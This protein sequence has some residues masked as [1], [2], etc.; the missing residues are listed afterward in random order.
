M[1][2]DNSLYAIMFDEMTKEPFFSFVMPAYK[3]SFLK[4]SI[5]SILA[6]TYDNF[7]LIIVDDAS[8]YNLN[9]IVNLYDDKRIK[10]YINDKNIG[11]HN[12]VEQWNRSLSYATG[13]YI[14]L[15][16]DDDV[17]MPLYL[18]EIVK[19]IKKYPDACIF[20]PRIQHIDSNG[21]I[22]GVESVMKEFTPSVEFLYNWI[23]NTIF[24][25]I[26]FYVFKRYKLNEIGNFMNY[27]LAWY[28][29]DH[30]V[31]EMSKKGIICSSEVLFSFRISGENIS[32]RKN[33]FKDVIQKLSA[34]LK[35]RDFLGEYVANLVPQ[36]DY[37]ICMA[38]SIVSK[39][40]RLW[41]YGEIYD[42]ISSTSYANLIRLTPM[43]LASKY[44]DLKML[45]R[46]HLRYIKSK[47]FSFFY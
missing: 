47:I 15:A 29:D 21:K 34:I 6:Q 22:I 38:E 12:L 3:A 5:S 24:R 26:P 32:N 14:V 41:I 36:Y 33:S 9:E 17:Y 1:F 23:N 39:V 44:V 28:S 25:G 27:P 2:C 8:P 10:Y 31:L 11:R 20:R 43:L 42:L 30:T 13:D 37:K 45:I 35:F 18:D 7:E 19:L 46:I 40:K 16:S 4:Q